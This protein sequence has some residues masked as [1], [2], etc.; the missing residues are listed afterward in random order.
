MGSRKL[1]RAWVSAVGTMAVA[2]CMFPTDHS[3][4]VAIVVNNAPTL[5]RVRDSVQIQATVVNSSGNPIVG[6]GTQYR[7]TNPG[8]ATV[9]ATGMIRAVAA[10]NA[11]VQVSSAGIAGTQR[12]VQFRVVERIT[13]DSVLPRTPVSFGGLLRVYGVG[14][15]PDSLDRAQLTLGGAPAAISSYTAADPLNPSLGGVLSVWA[16]PPADT[17]SSLRVA[18]LSGSATQANGIKVLQDDIF[19]PN[20]T[21]PASLG[22]VSDSFFNAGLAFEARGNI[23]RVSVDAQTQ[24]WY[25]FT[26]TSTRDIT[27]VLAAPAGLISAQVILADSLARGGSF[28]VPSRGA[29]RSVVPGPRLLA[30]TPTFETCG[31]SPSASVFMTGYSLAGAPTDSIVLPLRGLPAGKHQL[32]ILYGDNWVT[33]EAPTGTPVVGFLSVPQPVPWSV[34][35]YTFTPLAGYRLL[36]GPGYRAALQPD[37]FEPNNNCGRAAALTVPWSYTNLTLDS[38]GRNDW[39]KFT[40]PTAGHTYT[41]TLDGSVASADIDLLLYRSYLPDSVAFVNGSF[42]VTPHEQISQVLPVGTYFLVV[43][44]YAGIPTPY[45][46]TSGSVAAAVSAVP[47]APALPSKL[48]TL[49]DRLGTLVHRAAMGRVSW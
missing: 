23:P 19:E 13:I 22:T 15:V 2:A 12:D 39:Y 25:T 3:G 18:S 45:S 47:A 37:Q 28:S 48:R 40:V 31:T 30:T 17:V 4:S 27:V 33:F 24:D 26:T 44:D 46:L 42:S 11:D 41:F 32:L 43:S 20:D 49:R 1:I 29:N 34:S 35:G 21:M 6:A 7:S 8:V 5:M 10:G 9:D 38:P 36:I 14:L 16:G